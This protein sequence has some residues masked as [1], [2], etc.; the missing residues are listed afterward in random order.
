MPYGGQ[1]CLRQYPKKPKPSL[2]RSGASSTEAACYVS[3][4]A[5]MHRHA[6]FARLLKRELEIPRFSRGP[7]LD[8]TYPP[9]VQS[10]YY[11]QVLRRTRNISFIY[12]RKEFQM[13]LGIQPIHIVIII[14]VA[15]L[16]FGG[17]KL[18]EVGRSAGKAISEFRKGAKEMTDGF[19]EEVS[20]P[21]TTRAAGATFQSPSL[22][23]ANP[24]APSQTP[25]AASAGRFCIQCG[26]P[27]P[28]ESRFCNSCGTKLP[29]LNS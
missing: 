23:T 29:E 26:A 19:R 18:P 21:G 15:F 12:R 8:Q 5:R 22:S 28:P 27:N 6:P 16:I 2:C 4:A 13:P 9:A 20:Q 1:I 11:G 3:K 17:N 25:P 24:S 14:V 10:D 7:L